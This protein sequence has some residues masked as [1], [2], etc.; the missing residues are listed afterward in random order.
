MVGWDRW[1]RVRA[2]PSCA[3]EAYAEGVLSLPESDL[4]AVAAQYMHANAASHFV[5]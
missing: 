3:C 2:A 4:S 5:A 1:D